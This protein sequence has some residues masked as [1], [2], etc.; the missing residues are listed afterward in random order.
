MTITLRLMPRPFV[1]PGTPPRY[2]PDRPVSVQHVRLELEVDLAARRLTGRAVLTLR[3]RRDDVRRIELDAVD[4]TFAE[5]KVDG[6]LAEHHY[7]GEKLSIDVGPH[8]RGSEL[9][10]SVRYACS[11]R[12]GLYFIG[13]NEHQ[14]Q[15]PLQCW[16]QGQDEDARHFWPSIDV[17]AEKATS[18]VICTAPSHLFVLSNGEP[19]ER[20]PLPDGRTRWHY[21]LELPHPSYLVTLVCGEFVEV[22]D[23]APATGVDVFYHVAP[24]RQADARR[25]FGKT[26]A[27]I[28]HFASRIGI[29][30]PHGRYSQIAVSDFIL[31]GMENTSATTMT[32][33]VLL[34]ERAALDH[35]VEGLV[36]HE[37][38]HQWWGNLVTCRE[39]PEAW[40]NEGFATY[41]EYV[42]REF[43]YGRD[44][45][46]HEQL[47]D[48]EAYLN[49]S[50]KYQRPIVCRQYL[51]PIELFD[52]HLYDKAG[53]VLHM[54]RHQVGDEVFWPALKLYAERHARGSV[55]TRDLVRAIEEVSGLNVDRFFDQWIESPGHPELEAS[56][57]WDEDRKLGTV[58]VEQKQTGDTVFRFELKVEIE[59]PG[60]AFLVESF[61]VRDRTHNFELR[62]PERPLQVVLDPGDVILKRMKLDKPRPYWVRQLEHARLGVDRVLAARALG[63]QPGRESVSALAKA[64]GKAE[65]WAVRAAAARALGQIRGDEA[66]DALQMGQDDAHPKV[67]RAVAAALGEFTFDPVAGQLAAAWAL[68]GDPS[69][70]VEAAAALSAGRARAADALVVLPQLLERDS[71]Q[72]VIRVRALEG[73]GATGDERARSILAAAYAPEASF[74]ARRA[75]IVGLV[76]L[77]EGTPHV[78]Q[79]R[80]LLE[81]A[82]GDRDFRVRLEAA[83]GLG[84][85]GDGQAIAAL[86]RAAR[87]ELDGRAK[88][89]I[90]EAIVEINERGSA[91]EQT[92]KLGSDVE[93]LRREVEEL[94]QRLERSPLER[95][96]DSRSKAPSPRRPRP[97]SRR[98]AKGPRRRLK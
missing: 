33:Q 8:A 9:V 56:W 89:R 24:G 57:R 37:L 80:E 7:D 13:P 95:G 68:R 50:G 27:M 6:A 93:R 39:W 81:R 63:E 98:G 25:S 82:L 69:C 64:L 75:A 90:R 20:T 46:D 96:G 16:T 71:Y 72:D 52:A 77:C 92:R 62:L 83:T 17:P 4:M 26:P 15:R 22:R 97:P 11:P 42:W 43:A 94:R 21:S 2:L 14:P 66:R 40:L 86:E 34:D 5:I 32:D 47:A 87:G 10:V 54:L 18:E 31:G 51:A 85:L 1:P 59:R 78:R 41:F 48:T 73:L 53:R 88:R 45:A 58:K 35:D 38:A 74:Q 70:F 67:R 23:R 29:P 91:T 55:E 76:K 19:R 12:R 3:C 28:D 84:T 61:E 60:G 49:E 36:A 30:Y 44:V 79:A 65:F